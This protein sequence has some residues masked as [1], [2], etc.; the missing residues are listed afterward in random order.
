MFDLSCFSDEDRQ[1]C[2][3]ALTDMGDGADCMEEAAERIVGYLYENLG[4]S[5]G[6][7]A[8]ALVRFYKTHR[9]GD[10]TPELRQF[11]Q[12]V[13]GSPSSS[14]DMRRLALLAT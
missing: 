12:G 5:E 6:A 3:E 10:L 1:R 2:A 13:L 14:V 11:A 8:C 7:K 4:D 9:Y